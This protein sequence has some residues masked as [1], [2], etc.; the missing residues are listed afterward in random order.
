MITY[1]VVSK[2]LL[3][4]NYFEQLKHLINQNTKVS[5]ILRITNLSAY[6]FF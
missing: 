5:N 3:H 6:W 1:F 4:L 2:E